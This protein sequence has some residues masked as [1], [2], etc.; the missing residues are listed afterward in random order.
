MKTQNFKGVKSLA[1]IYLNITVAYENPFLTDCSNIA[2]PKNSDKMPPSLERV[3]EIV[4]PKLATNLR[5]D[6]L[7]TQLII[8]PEIPAHSRKYSGAKKCQKYNE[9]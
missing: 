9:V 8:Q 1:C 4:G 3:K 7:K 2:R 6:S 5:Y